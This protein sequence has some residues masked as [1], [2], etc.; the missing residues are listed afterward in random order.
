MS[1]L[2]DLDSVEPVMPTL[3]ATQVQVFPLREPLGKTQA[4]A[5]VV[6][7]DQLQLTGLRIV[8]GCNGL[9]VSYPND[10]SYKGDDYRA[11][12]YPLTKDFRE[13]I[14]QAVL[15]KYQEAVNA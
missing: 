6:L 1:K 5:R 11:M 9:F 15:A 8:D 7:N 3:V 12:F 14:E 4:L 10:P 13:H 2:K